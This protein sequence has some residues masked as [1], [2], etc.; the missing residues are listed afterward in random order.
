MSKRSDQ[1]YLLSQQYRDA[2]NL[3]A[4]INLHTRFKTNSYDWF[5][6][7]FDQFKLPEN[8]AILE[9]GCG[10]GN[11]WLSN[12]DRIPAGWEV[13]LSDF[14][15]G[16]LDEAQ[17]NLSHSNRSFHFNLIDAQQ[18]PLQDE[19][20]DAVVANHMLYHVPD[21]PMAI[22]EIHRVLKLNGFFFAATNG[23][24]H[25]FELDDL[26]K[27]LNPEL[28][29]T[30]DNTF[31]ANAFTLENGAEQL[32]PWFKVD[33]RY[34]EDALVVTEAEPLVAYL[35]SMVPRGD[36]QINPEQITALQ[37]IIEDRIRVEGCIRITKSTG[38]FISQ[39]RALS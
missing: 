33:I 4:R 38:L 12:L 30:I 22:S 31:S 2:S 18:L 37:H 24:K 25:L 35:L 20:L 17:K 9:L 21:R 39:K 7:V 36:F 27:Y 6:F 16:M 13:S 29:H 32:A 3:K 5:H 15:P 34:Y 10:P 8:A 19:R 11:L 23:T 26:Y 14:S 1:S 28:S